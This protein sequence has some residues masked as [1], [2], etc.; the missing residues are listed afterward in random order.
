M[1][2]NSRPRCG[3]V[4]R[5]RA[6]RRGDGDDRP[7][8]SPGASGG[9]CPVPSAAVRR[10]RGLHASACVLPARAGLSQLARILSSRNDI[11][12]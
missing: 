9:G 3:A 12:F 11:N 7:G 10:W 4:A 5:R 6:G 1:A 2:G 8:G